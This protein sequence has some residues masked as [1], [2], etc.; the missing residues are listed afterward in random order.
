[1]IKKS[2]YLLTIMS[3]ICALS[4][5]NESKNGSKDDGAEKKDNTPPVITGVEDKKF[6]VDEAVSYMKGVSASDDTDGNVEVSVDNSS[7]KRDANGKIVEG[8]YKIIYTAKDSSGNET[9]EEAVFTF[10][11]LEVTE[12]MVS[13]KAQEVLDGII[14]ADM[15]VGEKAKSIYDYIHENLVYTGTSD[16]DNYLKSAYLGLSTMSGDCYTCFAVSKALLNQIGAQT[17]DMERAPGGVLEG[18]HYWLMVDLGSG[19]YHFDALKQADEFDGFMRTD[20]AIRE[21]SEN[22]SI[23]YYNLDWDKEI[24]TPSEEFTY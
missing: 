2:L 13:E 9:R 8:S 12:E 5:C 6:T 11:E 17:V 1:M 23:G 3:M 18:D 15:P 4:A 10:E 24:K 20:E 7:V 21:Y 14:T 16:K 19:Y 22:I